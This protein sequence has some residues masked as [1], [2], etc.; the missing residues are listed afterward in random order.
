MKEPIEQIKK[1]GAELDRKADEVVTEGQ[2]LL[3][4]LKKSKWT[5]AAL[6]GAGLLAAF[7]IIK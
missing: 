4:K 7:L 3:E 5:A 1:A 6:T 2:T